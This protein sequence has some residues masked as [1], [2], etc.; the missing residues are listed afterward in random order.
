M[1]ARAV[2][3]TW[4]NE[5]WN[6]GRSQGCAA[7]AYLW[8]TSAWNKTNNLK[9][10]EEKQNKTK[11]KPSPR[12]VG[13][14]Y[15]PTLFVIRSEGQSGYKGRLGWV[16]AGQWGAKPSPLHPCPLTIPSLQL[17]WLPS[18]QRLYQ[19]VCKDVSCQA[20]ALPLAAS[21]FDFSRRL[22][23]IEAR[24]WQEALS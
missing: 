18:W 3:L 23:W 20:L 17:S 11:K 24:V 10:V 4:N 1:T 8:V 15:Y 14:Q 13:S 7:V 6:Y 9:W 22:P 12:K 16:C 2:C 5:C 19:T 21:P